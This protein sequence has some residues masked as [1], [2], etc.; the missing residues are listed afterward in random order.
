MIGVIELG[1]KFYNA[2][3]AIRVSPKN[4]YREDFKA[5]S[6]MTF[7]NAPNVF[8]KDDENHIEYEVAY[9]TKVFCPVDA[10]VDSV[11]NAGTQTNLGD[12]FKSFI[13][14]QDF[15]MP[16]YGQMFKWQNNYWI[17]INTNNYESIPISCVVRRCNNVL[18]WINKDGGIMEEPCIL[19][20]NIMEGTNYTNSNVV[21][22][23]G[24]LKAYCQKNERTNTIFSNQ[25][26]LFG[27]KEHREC[28]KVQGNG[29]R[30]FIN[31]ETENDE[32]PS[33]I[34]FELG[35]DYVN[36]DTDDVEN[37]VADR[38][39]NHFEISCNISEISQIVGFKE[40]IEVYVKKDGEVIY[41]ELVWESDDENIVYV[42]ENG[43]VELKS[44]GAT[45]VKCFVKNNSS[46]FVV[47]E[48]NVVDSTEND[49]YEII[50]SPDDTNVLEGEEQ[51]YSCYLYKNNVKQ[52]NTFE[53]S[54]DGNVPQSN[55]KL[56]VYDGNTFGVLNIKK[57]LKEY[58]KVV[59]KTG[60]YIQTINISL[61]GAW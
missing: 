55:Y 56:F 15:P 3:S 29:V 38:Y 27:N 49:F 31:I 22:T 2:E 46:L 43:N 5:I 34:E 39:K 54:I 42:D 4:S 21:L 40:Q 58:L 41:P 14:R 8:L 61:K 10:R 32:S 23:A 44:V 51:K 19:A 50:I 12:D 11:V 13:F 59:C 47:I 6:D 36:Y 30:N 17:V 53:F 45:S 37:G 35:A 33:Y 7:E 1:F 9:G 57:Y 18:R 26:F 48:I 16:Y 60:E 20:Y 24:S 28:Y 52:D 25:R